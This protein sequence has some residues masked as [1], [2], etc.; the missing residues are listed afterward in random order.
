[1]LQLENNEFNKASE[2]SA[3]GLE[4]FPAQPVLYLLNGRANNKLKK[5][6][7]AIESLEAGLDYLFE[8]FLILQID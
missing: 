6:D 8:D 3:K 2:L 1:M 4:V 5:S 7:L